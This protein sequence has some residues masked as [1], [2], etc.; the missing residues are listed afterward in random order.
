MYAALGGAGG[1]LGAIV[2]SERAVSDRRGRYAV[3]RHGR[4]YWTRTTGAN[5]VHGSILSVF[6]RLG[7]VHGFL[8]YPTSDTRTSADGRSRYSNFEGGRIYYW[9]RGRSR[10]MARSS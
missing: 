8:G 10:S 4:I 7:G 1:F 9:S 6:S 2:R 5:E 3:Y